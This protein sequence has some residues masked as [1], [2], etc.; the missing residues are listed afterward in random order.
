[1]IRNFADA[2]DHGDAVFGL[3]GSRHLSSLSSKRAGTKPTMDNRAWK[4]K[5]AFENT[6]R[7]GSNNAD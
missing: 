1:M 7:R 4:I 6:N 2:D 5:Y 3:P